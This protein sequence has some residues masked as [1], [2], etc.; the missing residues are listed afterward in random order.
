MLTPYG[1]LLV[2]RHEVRLGQAVEEAEFAAPFTRPSSL[3]RQ[4][5][6]NAEREPGDSRWILDTPGADRLDQEE[7]RVVGEIFDRSGA[8]PALREGPDGRKEPA[9]H[10]SL[11]LGIAPERACLDRLSSGSV[12][13]G[14]G[15]SV[16]GS[17]YNRGLALVPSASSSLGMRRRNVDG[18]R[19][20]ERG[21]RPSAA[22]EET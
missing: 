7:Q 22:K 17:E 6:A 5:P 4:I 1:E 12:E 16:H 11:S 15:I 18:S 13:S 9:T 10:F 8:E 19:A 20:T 21:M 14:R 3:A 2:P